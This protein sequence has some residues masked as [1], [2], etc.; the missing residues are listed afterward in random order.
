MR[1]MVL[2]HFGARLRL[3]DR[4]VPVP[5]PGEVL[6]Q[7]KACGVCQ[8]DLKILRGGHASSPRVR[9]PH[10]PGH[11]VSGIVA[12]IGTAV[13][14]LELG[15]AVV[16]NIY[17]ICGEC[18]FCQSGRESL[19]ANL[20]SW[21][22]FD[23]P[24]GMADYLRVPARNLVRIPL[25]MPIEQAAILGDAVA[26]CVRAVKTRGEIR[27]GEVTI[28]TGVG[29]VGIH[30]VQIARSLGSR[31]IAADVAPEK[32]ALARRFGAE[33]VTAGAG[34]AGAVRSLTG[35]KG[36]HVALDFT[37]RPEALAA[38]ADA[39]RPGGRLV[40][41]GYQVDTAV[42]VPTQAVVL[43]ELEVRGSRY[44]NRH[45]LAEAVDLVARGAVEPVIGTYL[46]L[47][48]A[49]EGVEL[50]RSGAV[51]GRLVLTI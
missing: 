44:C 50:L 3:A 41:V 17:D 47:E 20:G 45:E 34:M 31:V 46:P 22:G 1:A 19:C 26:T 15:D 13:S 38:Q 8:T 10:T 28:V 51:S 16:V 30:A 36:A 32:L 39:L 49:N 5:G 25:Y 14:G 21:I 7:V 18:E 24:G 4:P 29:G 35:G 9:F 12:Q 48:Q 6:I 2:D 33:V 37:G 42:A 40:M 23:A 11:E 43:K 27:E